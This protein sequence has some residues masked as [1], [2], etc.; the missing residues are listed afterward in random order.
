[1]STLYE[2]TG[3]YVTLMD[4]LDDPEVDPITLMDTL[5][6]VEGELDEKAENYGR[7]IRNLEAEA[8]ALKEE[9]DRL[10]RRKKTIDNNIDSLKKRLQMAM[11]LT[12]RPKIDTPLFKFY[13]QKNAPS[14]V[15]DLDD[16]QDMPME[17]LTYHEPTVNKAAIKDALKAGLD[18]TGIAHLEQSQSLRIR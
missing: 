6:A 15:V 10:S 4:M 2:L 13:I 14:V 9:V 1:M 8:T 12:N 17:Y 3:N 7:I 11:E 18:L 5:D 16:L